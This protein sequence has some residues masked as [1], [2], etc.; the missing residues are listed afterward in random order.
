MSKGL[1]IIIGILAIA[2]LTLSVLLFT[3]LGVGMFGA[4]TA[5]GPNHYQADVF[6]Q[7]LYGGTSRQLSISNSGLLTTSG[8]IIN[9]GTLT[10]SAALTASSDVRL[11]SPVLTG[12]IAS[13][14]QTAGATTSVITAAQVCDS[15]YATTTP[16]ITAA[17]TL[18]TPSAVTLFAD[19]LT[20]NGDEVSL[21]VLNTTA[22]TTVV[23]AGASSTLYYDGA[24]GGSATLA[25]SS[26]A[27]LR[28]VRTSATTLII[29]M[30]QFKP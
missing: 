23:T 22:S 9:S 17:S 6:L 14:S 13:I 29:I 24:T 26:A 8:G 15:N 3:G 27:M 10:Q 25:A 28:F 20:T 18:T 30:N 2:V 12:S 19:C 5:F 16:S 7:G 11:K 1:K 4:A 21:I